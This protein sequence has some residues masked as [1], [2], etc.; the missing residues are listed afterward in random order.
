M[1]LEKRL[2]LELRVE[3]S[4]ELVESRLSRY[5]EAPPLLIAEGSHSESDR[6]KVGLSNRIARNET[7]ATAA[8]C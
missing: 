8:R 3:N 4:G 2:G 6:E 5:G 7:T 1:H